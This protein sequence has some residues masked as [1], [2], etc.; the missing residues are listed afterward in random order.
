MNRIM[1]Y[2][3]KYYHE[4]QEFIELAKTEEIELT[5]LREA[6]Q[7]LHEDQFVTTSGIQAIKRREQVLGIQADPSQESLDFR[8]KRIINRYSTKPPFT[9][10]YMQ[11]RLDYLVGPERVVVTVDPFLFILTV[12]ADIE[13]ASIFA[14]VIRTVETTKPANLVYQQKTALGDNIGLEE[15]LISRTL[16]RR[17]KLSTEW[18]LGSTPFADV[19]AE[20]IIK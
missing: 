6:V 12:T 17:T 11:E 20:V 1:E 9:M 2:W 4:I 19:D 5:R 7:R 16:T 8:K 14:E 15:R 10:R 13:D 18:R 3:P